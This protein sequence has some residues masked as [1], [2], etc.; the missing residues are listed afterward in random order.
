[1]EFRQSTQDDLNYVRENPFEGAVKDYPYLEVPDDNC[2]T[3][4][5]ED[6]IVAVYGL[7]SIWEGV[8]WVWLIMTD[9][10]KKEGVFGIIAIHAIRDKLEE[11][12]KDNNIRRAQAR[13]RPD[14]TEA[15]KMIE[16][17]GF[18]NETPDGMK[19][20]FP[21]RGDGYLYSR[22]C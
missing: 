6:Q 14:F 18:K 3:A 12:L 21:D 2:Y 7:Q 13:M 8:A 20:Y 4:I 5:F 17:L 11:L 16:F 1:M 22:L 15:I 9:D 10:C 19:E